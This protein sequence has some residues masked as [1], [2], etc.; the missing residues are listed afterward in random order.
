MTFRILKKLENFLTNILGH[1][2]KPLSKGV[3]IDFVVFVVLEFR[4]LKSGVGDFFSLRNTRWH[5]VMK[6][7]SESKKIPDL[8]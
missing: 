3:A 5:L 6:S 1:K 4:K 8:T 2:I 7:I